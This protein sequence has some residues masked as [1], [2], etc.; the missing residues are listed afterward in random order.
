MLEEKITSHNS[1][2]YKK[3]CS[4]ISNAKVHTNCKV[5]LKLDI[6]NFF[7]S[8]NFNMVYNS[9]FNKALYPKK[10]GMLLTNLCMY[11]NKLSQG[12]PTSG[13]ISNIVL[14]DFDYKVD[15][16]C[17]KKMINY[18]RY[19]DD[20]TFSGNFEVRPLIKM[21]NKLLYKK[22]FRLNKSK[23]KV[24]WHNTRQQVYYILKY[25]VDNHI[26]RK[27]I[28]LS[29]HKYLEKL[30]GKINYILSVNPLDIKFISYKTKLMSLKNN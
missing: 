30:I 27:N 2:A 19:S 11:N 13:Y 24:I 10:M 7:D 25:G 3:G 4:A 12:A 9:C 15:K 22:G 17:M 14:R 26:A 16:Y 5:I 20:M 29:S 28:K 23:I 1:H 8:I 18:T 21:I 6:K